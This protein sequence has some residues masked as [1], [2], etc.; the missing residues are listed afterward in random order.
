[1]A[2]QPGPDE[3]EKYRLKACLAAAAPALIPL[4]M[5][6]STDSLT[7]LKVASLDRIGLLAAVVVIVTLSYLL[8]RRYWWAG[9]PAM[10]V[11]LFTGGLFAIKTIRPLYAYFSVNSFNGPE[12][13]LTPLMMV[14]PALVILLMSF[15]LGRLTFRGMVMAYR[16][17]PTPISRA[18]WG[19]LFIWAAMLIGDA[20]Y[21]E[22]GWR[23]VK[24]PTDVVL[25]LCLGD[26]AQRLEAERIL[27][28]LGPKAVPALRQAMEVKDPGLDCLRERSGAIFRQLSIQA[29]AK[30]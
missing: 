9:L 3:K 18:A 29:N 27:L 1:M 11:F 6:I 30:P 25:R 4:V 8:F 12:G 15:V 23:Y 5:I 14:S 22:V 19:I 16:D 20:A 26:K 24:N 2:F 17:K 21:Q 28:E 7:M 10:A 13:G